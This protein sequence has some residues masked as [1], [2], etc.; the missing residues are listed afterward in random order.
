MGSESDPPH[1]RIA[2]STPVMELKVLI[3]LTKS[4]CQSAHKLLDWMYT[5]Q[6][7]TMVVPNGYVV[8][9]VT[10]KLAG[11]IISY[12]AFWSLSCAEHDVIHISFKA[13]YQYG[14]LYM[15]SL[16]DDQLCENCQGTT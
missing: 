2:P 11:T 10:K 8:Y 13:S 7:D 1:Y 3:V 4:N 15:I 9:L 5:T 12:D 14:T 16:S 6:E